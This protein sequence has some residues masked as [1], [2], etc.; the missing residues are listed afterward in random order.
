MNPDF[1]T[2]LT[3]HWVRRGRAVCFTGIAFSLLL[4]FYDLGLH[5]ETAGRTIP[6]KLGTVLVLSFLAWATYQNWVQ[7]I[8]RGLAPLSACAFI[9]A[10]DWSF[11][12]QGVHDKADRVF[13]FTASTFVI[14]YLLPMRA[15]E[16][17]AYLA[18]T[19]ASYFLFGS[20][21]GYPPV[22]TF[23]L[24]YLAQG[25]VIVAVG[26]IGNR[27]YLATKK[28]EIEKTA[29]L[30]A[31]TEGLAAVSELV[32]GISHEINNPLASSYSLLE[33][34]GEDMENGVPAGEMAESLEM[35]IRQLARARAL[36]E[37]L[38]S[39][40]SEVHLAP[41]SVDLRMLL[42][43]VIQKL[44]AA[45][46]SGLF[47]FEEPQRGLS[48][49]ATY[50][51]LSRVF[52]SL[53]ENAVEAEE[54]A[55]KSPHVRVRVENASPKVRIVIEDHG[56][57]IPSDIREKIFQPFFTTRRDQHRTGL[58]LYLA[59]EIVRSLGGSISVSSEL[60]EGS[61]FSVE[62]PVTEQAA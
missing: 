13:A 35:A 38:K 42:R 39:L 31:R 28:S 54:R 53:F 58:G 8:I 12:V 4:V 24:P 55:G 21:Y 29:A 57:G 6:I 23:A 60:N 9:A 62:L 48:V 25:A 33:S 37:E 44:E 52:H 51:Q 40:A 32:N 30:E 14:F 15:R 5:T 41:A 56:V 20:L 16:G 61:R 1:E 18:T 2:F 45:K 19:Y 26:I 59:H 17:L 43:D 7:R 22:S 10:I 50:A 27:V 47:A 34:L 36:I 46:K 11:H 3:G 49:K